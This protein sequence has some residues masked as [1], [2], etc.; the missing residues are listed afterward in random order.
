MR[1]ATLRDG[2][3]DGTLVLVS[4]DGA[5]CAKAP[6]GTLQALL[7]D[8]ARWEPALR[9]TVEFTEP[10]EH[11]RLCAPLPRAWQWLDGSDYKRM[12]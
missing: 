5:R 1:L 3:R 9:A 11:A 4:P 10:L 7:E 2:T 12:Y 8:W 6:V